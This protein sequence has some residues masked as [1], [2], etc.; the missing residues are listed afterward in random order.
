MSDAL[1]Q[2][3]YNPQGNLKESW[4][5]EEV[6]T[7]RT[8][9]G[10]GYNF[11]VPKN[12]PFFRN[13]FKL[14]N[15]TTKQELVEGVDFILTHPFRAMSA[16]TGLELFG[17][18][19][20]ID[21]TFTGNLQVNYYTLGGEFVLDAAQM[22][23][24]LANKLYNPRITF[25]ERV[26][27]VPAVFPPIN[28]QHNIQ[29]DTM[30]WDDV[31][32]A[33]DALRPSMEAGYNKAMLA[34]T[35][36]AARKDNPHGLTKEQIN[37]GLVQNFRLATMADIDSTGANLYMTL[38]VTRAFI[39]KLAM[40][41]V[42]AHINN[43]NN[44]HGTTKA[45]VQLGLVNNYATATPAET[46]TGT[47]TTLYTTPAGVAALIA[48]RM[49][50]MGGDVGTLGNRLTQHENNKANPHGTTKAH[51]Q[52]GNVQNYGIATSEEALRG[53]ATDKYMTPALVSAFVSA[54]A[55]V[56][57]S[58]HINDKANPHGVTKAQVQLGSVNNY[59]TASSADTVTG[60]SS[61]LYTTPAGVAAAIAAGRPTL[62][63]NHIA[64]LAN[65]HQTT[66]AQVQ[67]GN[68]QNYGMATDAQAIDPALTTA[69]M[70]PKAV[71]LAVTKVAG[72]LL[73]VHANNK[74][75]PHGVTK[76]QVQL[77]NVQNY[78]IATNAEAEAGT[79]TDKYMT[80]ALV[81][82]MIAKIQSGSIASH[83]ADKNNPHGVTKAQVQLGNVQNFGVAS[84]ADAVNQNDVG[85]YMTPASTYASI[86]KFG[87]LATHTHTAAQVGALPI[88]GGILTGPLTITTL[89][90]NGIEL[91]G[92]S[93]NISSRTATIGER[94]LVTG[95][96]RGLG[97]VEVSTI[98]SKTISSL[99]ATGLIHGTAWVNPNSK[100][101]VE[102]E[103]NPWERDGNGDA[104]VP[105]TVGTLKDWLNTTYATSLGTNPSFATSFNTLFDARW[106]SK[107]N[108]SFDARFKTN[109]EA[110]FNN[111]FD[112][113]FTAQHPAAFTTQFNSAFP[114][115]F[116][117]RWETKFNPAW[118]ARFNTQHPTAFDT[119]W[120]TKF[121][122]AFD[123]RF[124]TSFET[125]W[126]SKFPGAFDARFK[127]AYEARFKTDFQAQFAIDHPVAF[128]ARWNS[129]FQTE[130][131]K[132]FNIAY[133]RE[134]AKLDLANY[135]SGSSEITMT[136]DANGKYILALAGK[137]TKAWDS[138][139]D[140]TFEYAG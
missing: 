75:N 128:D 137:V 60:T 51:V 103:D 115:A 93:G 87:A 139:G 124:A 10:E 98:D 59:G 108:T 1:T 96:L 40:D 82:V 85:H 66:K 119:R 123:A 80:P 118:D 92:G 102:D 71:N 35:Q 29:T 109:Y 114:S 90:G 18:F 55:S 94:L 49:E 44:P 23:T 17:S 13:E 9:T 11:V 36:H 79:A 107:F 63:V 14:Y 4:V 91:D 77:G 81:S 101:P 120:N 28:H 54:N 112:T 67:L 97:Y 111:D 38:E 6:V 126:N 68:V 76:A 62:V 122:P 70:S 69:Y 86:I 110:R 30:T 135:I 105:A 37:L 58:N 73:A 27:E 65:P 31:V 32:K 133:A 3:P 140:I 7:V 127:T 25:W 20:M 2:Y 50:S 121:N 117:T 134:I 43:K 56:P 88:G 45:Q 132:A 42:N 24:M 53:E 16:L 106:N 116:D 34:V 136:K 61:S 12:A 57:L 129:K 64:D 100:A 5:P 33:I 125:S 74:A 47:S 89:R 48:N 21:R 22:L 84:N 39:N 78:A 130:F 113:R 83:I 41:D 99:D 72:D 52:L 104:I 19:M 15:P 131:D 8:S 138:A 95:N 46:I 26:A